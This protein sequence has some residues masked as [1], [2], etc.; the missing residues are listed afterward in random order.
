RRVRTH[1]R[2]HRDATADGS[3]I[4]GWGMK[5]LDAFC[6]QGGASKG[7]ADAGFEV[8]GIDIQPQS[9]YPYDFVLGDA[10]PF[11]REYGYEFDAI[12]A[13]PPCQRYSISQTIRGREYPDLIA[14][15]RTAILQTGRPYVIE[16]VE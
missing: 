7:Y 16:N 14:V 15:T 3:W 1:G 11:I 6:C 5:I 4:R 12:H 9:R 10:V 13:S 8:V 2:S